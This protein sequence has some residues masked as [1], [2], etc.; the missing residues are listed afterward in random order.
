MLGVTKFNPSS[1]AWKDIKMK[2]IEKAWLAG[3]FD[4]EGCVWC[5]FP[6]AK[7]VIV[8]IK[9]THKKTMLK[10]NK[11]FPGRLVEG[12]LSGW[13]IK[14]QWK[15]S[16]DTNGSK[17]FLIMLSPYLVT[18]KKEAEIAIRLCDRTGAENLAVLAKRLKASR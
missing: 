1:A 7:N 6:K 14:P 11:L 9:M 3:I 17:K 8:E 5:R 16:L 13:S 12:N 4:G 10:I 18:K 15:W 2:N